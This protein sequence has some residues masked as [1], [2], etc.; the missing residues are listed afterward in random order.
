MIRDAFL[1][2][3]AIGTTTQVGMVVVGHHVLAVKRLFGLGGMLLSALAG[4]LFARIS[5]AGWSEIA[6]CG[7]LAGAT[8][9]FLGIGIS[10]FHKDVPGKLLILG[11]V[12]SG[13]AGAVGGIVAK[14]IGG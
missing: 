14:A 6:V 2:A 10:Y 5:G 7:G 4:L 3:T 1:I 11:T 13:I 12:A 8:C 9:A